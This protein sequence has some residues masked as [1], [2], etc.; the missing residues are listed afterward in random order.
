M[1]ES[2]LMPPGKPRNA[3][4]IKDRQIASRPKPWG[5]KSQVIGYTETKIGSSEQ[6]K[7]ESYKLWR[8]LTHNRDGPTWQNRPVPWAIG[9]R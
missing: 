1:D 8:V 5:A 9:R 4:D 7:S 3:S 6:K 2:N